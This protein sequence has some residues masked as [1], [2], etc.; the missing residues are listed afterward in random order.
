ME[1][2]RCRI[3]IDTGSNVLIVRPDIL[4]NHAGSVIQPV[5]SCLKTVTSKWAPI[6]GR[7]ELSIMLGQTFSHCVWIADIV[8]ECLLGLD[9]L[10]SH[11]CQVDLKVVILYLGQNE[12]L[13]TQPNA[14]SLEQL[15]YHAV[16]TSSV[17][18][19]PNSDMI[20]PLSVEGLKGA[21][22]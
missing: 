22:R 14:D 6:R 1:H 9:F 13:L 12:I 15:C 7:I 8:D 10:V 17:S 11:E 21:E 3:T 2:R 20:V 5:E 16:V 4:E 19:P 18:L